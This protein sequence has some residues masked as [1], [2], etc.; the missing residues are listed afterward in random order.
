MSNSVSIGNI[1]KVVFVLTE[2]YLFFTS[3]FGFTME[4]D[5]V[6]Y[7][8]VLLCFVYAFGC[9]FA[10]KQGKRDSQYILLGLFFT[11]IADFFLILR[12]S[13]YEAGITAFFFAQCCY[14]IYLTVQWNQEKRTHSFK[15][16]IIIAGIL[17]IAVMVK[18][19]QFSMFALVVTLYGVF[20]IGNVKAAVM[21]FRKHK[22][23]TVGLV[24]FILCDI[25]VGVSN[26]EMAG[27]QN[28]LKY[29][30]FELV[31]CFYIPSQVCIALSIER[32]S[33]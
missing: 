31:W 6:H 33:T 19:R 28:P 2:L 4:V 7:I 12:N 14:F 23:Y 25:C 13:L 1:S 21:E 20:F 9:V 32:K 8:C 29:V 27:I 18:A 5:K 3:Q 22:L 24:L 11:C 10:K 17:S 15:L 30:F 26:L 16:R